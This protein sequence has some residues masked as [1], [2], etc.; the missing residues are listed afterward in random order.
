MSLTDFTD[1]ALPTDFGADGM[2]TDLFPLEDLNAEIRA[3]NVRASQHDSLPLTLYTYTRA[4]QYAEH[5]N[6]VT[7]RCRGLVVE[8]HTGHVV[9]WCLP[10]FFNH[11]QH[12]AQHPFAPPLPD[13][14]FEVYDKIDGSLGIVFWYEGTWLA[15][16]KGS[17]HSDQAIWAQ[18]WL[19]DHEPNGLLV[20]GCTYITEIIYPNN[21]IV[22]DYGGEQTL[23]LLAVYG[24][25]GTEH[26]ITKHTRWWNGA[27][28][29]EVDYSEMWHAL[30]GRVVGS[31][32]A[33][34]LAEL[35]SR[36]E[37]NIKLDGTAA[38]GTDA[39]GWVI[40]FASGLRVKVK[41]DE[42]QRLHKRLTGTTSIDIWRA[43]GAQRFGHLDPVR[44]A[45]TIGVSKEEAGRLVG[46]ETD[47]LSALLADAPDEFDQ[48]VHA[49]VDRLNQAYWEKVRAINMSYVAV[50]AA[51]GHYN[52][53]EPKS[54]RMHFAV[55]A[56]Q[57][58]KDPVI[59][60]GCFQILDGRDIG[61]HVWRAIR[62]ASTNPFRDDR[63]Q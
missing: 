16:S 51:V 7:T 48:W 27:E 41:L 25:D 40:R 14:P 59:R 52:T 39:E 9:A 33:L 35:V 19:K 49:T 22:V 57:Q 11:S 37:K 1:S 18:Q 12:G 29:S 28:R 63:D 45:Q 10:K 8:S 47:A 4:C 54:R 2:L 3:G 53:T 30:G 42:Y 20:P 46:R 32:P 61:P 26:H 34:P 58:V 38:V 13:E 6:P 60:S 15:A 31:H 21:R 43:C 62:P 55:A 5:W 23:V 44:L 17:F 36:A 50:I 24:P 56:Q